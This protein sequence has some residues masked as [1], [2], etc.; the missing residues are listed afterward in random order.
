MGQNEVCLGLECNWRRHQRTV[1]IRPNLETATVMR[2]S[3][4]FFVF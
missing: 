3:P 2:T 4:D 1:M